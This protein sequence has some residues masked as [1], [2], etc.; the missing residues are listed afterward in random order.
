MKKTL[1]SMALIIASMTGVSAFAQTTDG[2]CSKK[3][4][5]ECSKSCDK[6]DAPKYN[7]FAG[8]NLTEKQQAELQAL[9]PSKDAKSADKQDKSKQTGKEDKQA[10]RKQFA[11][12]KRDYLAKVKS[13]LTPDQYVQFLENSYVD[14]PMMKKGQGHKDMAKGRDGKRMDKQGGKANRP[15][16]DR[17]DFHANL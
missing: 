1:L 4:N 8:L 14:Q 17:S 12:R 3:A 15:S 13:I 16:K 5:T 6:K 10:M 7:P 2:T 9:K 11:E